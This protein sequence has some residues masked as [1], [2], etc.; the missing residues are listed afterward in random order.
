MRNESL[1]RWE[2]ALLHQTHREI[3]AVP[4]RGQVEPPIRAKR[5]NIGHHARHLWKHGLESLV[6]YREALILEVRTGGARLRHED[7][8]WG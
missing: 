4:L 2:L 5:R 6:D 3:N 8:A 1:V 7:P